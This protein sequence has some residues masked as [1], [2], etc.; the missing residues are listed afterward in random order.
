[1]V[2]SAVPALAFDQS[3]APQRISVMPR[4]GINRDSRDVTRSCLPS[5]SP[6]TV[7]QLFGLS[8]NQWLIQ[9]AGELE[10][11]D[12]TEAAKSQSLRKQCR[13]GPFAAHTR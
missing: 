5:R 11:T 1:M 3:A 9:Q 6:G 12:G 7:S 2:K 8:R 13:T 4:V 10:S